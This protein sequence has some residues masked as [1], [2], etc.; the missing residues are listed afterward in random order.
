MLRLFT[1]MIQYSN[2]LIIIFK[3]IDE[4]M[5]NKRENAGQFRGYAFSIYHI[6]AAIDP[7][8][9]NK[10]LISQMLIVIELQTWYLNNVL[11]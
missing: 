3:N 2:D 5:R 7:K 9:A 4:T 8:V 10:L 1:I 11:P 6:S